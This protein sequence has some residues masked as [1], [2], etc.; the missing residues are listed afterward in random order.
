MITSTSDDHA[1]KDV[2]LV[3][4]ALSD[5][6]QGDELT[7]DYGTNYWYYELNDIIKQIKDAIDKQ[8]LSKNQILEQSMQFDVYAHNLFF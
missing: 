5:I 6:K 2:L 7:I 1:T 3:A 4:F 8:V